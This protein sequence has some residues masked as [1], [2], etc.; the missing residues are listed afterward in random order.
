MKPEI[1]LVIS[2]LLG[3]VFS[4]FINYVADVLPLYRK[5]TNSACD[6]CHSEFGFDRYLLNRPCRV[7]G[8]TVSLRHRIVSS[9]IFLGAILIATYFFQSPLTIVQAAFVF[10]FFSL[11]IVIDIEHHL[12]L[13]SVSL[14]GALGMGI[15]GYIKHGVV[16]TLLGG[17]TGFAIMLFLYFIGI[18]FGRILSKRR[19][20]PVEEGL[21]FGDVTLAGV[22]GL[23]LGW[24]GIIVGLFF[25]ILLGGVYSLILI[26]TSLVRKEYRPFRT[27]PYG[28]FIAMAVFVLWI[29]RLS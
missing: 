22:C 27:I 20:T 23:L 3:W 10:L 1:L 4:A 24:P 6:D 18:W 15:I 5:L 26:I 28:P 2:A 12:I 11:V 19:G 25:G 29:M 16:V 14:I 8:K 13:H 21:G 9:T 7:C 17:V